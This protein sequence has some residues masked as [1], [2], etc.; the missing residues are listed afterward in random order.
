MK[1][2]IL[3]WS[4]RHNI[5]PGCYPG[6]TSKIGR[7]V[8]IVSGLSGH[9]GL[10]DHS[11]HKY[12]K[13]LQRLDH[14]YW[15]GP[16]GVGAGVRGD[17]GALRVRGGGGGQRGQGEERGGG[18]P[19]RGRGAGGGGAGGRGGAEAGCVLLPSV[20]HQL[21]LAAQPSQVP[22]PGLLTLQ[23]HHNHHLNISS[24][25]SGKFIVHNRNNEECPLS[26]CVPGRAAG[27]GPSPSSCWRG[28]G[29]W[30]CWPGRGTGTA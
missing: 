10:P 5:F 6:K 21:V 26:W 30:W 25:S 4:F 3:V 27:R 13:A 20:H 24:M 8:D 17:L 23:H 9:S 22:V 29:S 1:Q 19:G 12:L 7:A 14:L 18:L 15:L 11:G 16:A 2:A 28:A